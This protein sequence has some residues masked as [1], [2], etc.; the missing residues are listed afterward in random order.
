MDKK[1]IDKLEKKLEQEIDYHTNDNIKLEDKKDKMPISL[2]VN[3]MVNSI[4]QIEALKQRTRENEIKIK[5]NRRL[6]K[7]FE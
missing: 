7:R 3:K 5:E 4:I 1:L 6:T 2:G